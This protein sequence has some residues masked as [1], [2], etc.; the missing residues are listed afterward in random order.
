MPVAREKLHKLGR[1]GLILANVIVALLLLA[2]AA[3][4][5]L[6]SRWTKPTFRGKEEAFQHGT[7]GTELMPLALALVLPDLFPENFKP[8]GKQAGDWIEQFGFIRNDPKVSDGLP[9]GFTATLS[10]PQ[11][12]SPSPAAFVGFSCALCHST[13]IRTDADQHGKVFYGPGSNSL[14]LFAWLDAFQASMLA[15][16]PLPP[17]TSF[18]PDDPPPYRL[19]SSLIVDS[20]EAKTGRKLGLLERG[21]IALWLRQIRS[22]TVC[23]GSMSR[24]AKA[25]RAIRRSRRPGRPGRSR[26]AP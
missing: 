21:M 18:D 9:V 26:S 14:N 7:I 25:G 4:I 20:Y 22:R 11:S 6:E 19:T 23:R 24:S 13:V 16:E 5:V 1:I 17:G 3:L 12:G 2:T 10:R 8:A 15:R